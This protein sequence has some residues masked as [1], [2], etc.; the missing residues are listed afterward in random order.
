MRSWQVVVPSGLAAVAAV[1]SDVGGPL[2]IV[3][4]CWFLLA[5]P[6]L[7]LVRMLQLADTELEIALTIGLGLSIDVAVSLVLVV[8]GVYEPLL[9]LVLIMAIAMIGSLADAL[10]GPVTRDDHCAGRR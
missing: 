9:T 10:H 3:L 2:Q 8:A 5:C 6:A 7:G 4:A 1:L